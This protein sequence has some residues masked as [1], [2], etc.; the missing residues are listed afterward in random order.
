MHAEFELSAADAAERERALELVRRVA[1]GLGDY[2]PSRAP[3][4]KPLGSS[5]HFAGTMRMGMADDGMSVCDPTG[6]V[7]GIDNLHVAGNGVSPTST[8]VNP[9]SPAPRLQSSQRLVCS[10]TSLADFAKVSKHGQLVHFSATIERS[11]LRYSHI[12]CS[13]EVRRVTAVTE[14]ARSLRPVSMLRS[15]PRPYSRRIVPANPDRG[16]VRGAGPDS[17]DRLKV[18]SC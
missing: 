13:L 12:T 4:K 10:P 17:G 7:W 6:K 18:R 5:M 8:T 15:T 1:T 9:L 3:A 11:P 2:L 16:R 14:R